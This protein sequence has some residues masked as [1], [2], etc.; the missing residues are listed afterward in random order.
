MLHTEALFLFSLTLACI[1]PDEGETSATEGSSSGAEDNSDETSDET[2]TT[3]SPSTSSSTIDT[4]SSGADSIDSD[5]QDTS[6]TTAGTTSEED[7]EPVCGDGK[8]NGD[9]EC[10]D[11]LA[12]SDTAACTSICKL[13][14]CGDG[15]IQAGKEACDLEIKNGDGSYGGCTDRGIRV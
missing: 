3:S 7:I 10:D 8:I 15:L 2:S 14:F 9:E 6:G 1:P 13:A 4:T 11:G 12:N 5:P